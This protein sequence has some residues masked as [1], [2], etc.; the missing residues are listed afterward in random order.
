MSNKSIYIKE[1]SST[2]NNFYDL[3]NVIFSIIKEKIAG[4]SS[5]N[6]LINVINSN[7]S[8]YSV[9]KN[10]V[11][12]IL[13]YYKDKLDIIMNSLDSILPKFYATYYGGDAKIALSDIDFSNIM[14]DVAIDNNGKL[15]YISFN[16]NNSYF[17]A[18]L[19]CQ[20]VY[21]YKSISE[22]KE[23]SFIFTVNEMNTELKTVTFN[24]SDWLFKLED[25]PTITDDMNY[26]ELIKANPQLL[27]NALHQQ[28]AP[29]TFNASCTEL[30]IVFKDNSKGTYTHDKLN[31]GLTISHSMQRQI[32]EMPSAGKTSNNIKAYGTRKIAGTIELSDPSSGLITSFANR[33]YSVTKYFNDKENNEMNPDLLKFVKGTNLYPDQFPPFHIYSYSIPENGAAGYIL[34]KAIYGIRLIGEGVVATEMDNVINKTWEFIADG[35]EPDIILNIGSN[36]FEFYLSAFDQLSEQRS[37]DYFTPQIKF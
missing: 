27:Y 18:F 6:K 2:V 24:S 30:Y 37:K 23:L 35:F 19:L 26:V 13:T 3:N 16:N 22:K 32:T 11:N 34:F 8:A 12:S 15:E 33:L 4:G 21:F 36:N 5:A 10:V 25:K 1:Y 14:V 17:S 31:T 9:Y 20:L 28:Y 29:G 7:V